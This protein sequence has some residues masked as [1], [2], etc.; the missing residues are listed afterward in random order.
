MRRAVT[1]AL[2]SMRSA[3]VDTRSTREPLAVTGPVSLAE[4]TQQV[5]ALH[6]G[7]RLERVL[8]VCSVLV[9]DSPVGTRDPGQVLVAPGSSV[10]FLPP[11]AG[12]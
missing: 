8:A 10:E 5:L 7:S 4:V 12:G 9:G 3:L 6:R 11:F 2:M 1:A